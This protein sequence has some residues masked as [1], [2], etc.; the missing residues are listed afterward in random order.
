[1]KKIL[2]VEDEKFLVKALVEK[3]EHEGYETVVAENGQIGLEKALAEKPDCILL[4][5]LMPV[6]D[7]ISML[8]D[9]RRTEKDVHVPVILLS[10]LS[11]SITTLEAMENGVTDYL[12]KSD[13]KLEDVIM[14]IEEVT[15]DK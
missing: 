2:I 9:L 13:W 4:D 5:V 15:S 8:R 10:N 14:K 1:M 11:D 6:K 12:V 7:G 3:L